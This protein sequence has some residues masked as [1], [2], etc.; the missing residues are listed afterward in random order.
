MAEKPKY[1][2]NVVKPTLSILHKEVEHRMIKVEDEV[3]MD[4]LVSELNS[5]M[6]NNTGRGKSDDVKDKLY[7][8]AIEKWKQLKDHLIGVH[9]NF[10][11]NRRQY[12][13]LTDLLLTKL[14]YDANTIFLAIELTDMLGEWKEAGTNKDDDSIKGYIADATEINY[15]YHLI[16]KHKMNGLTVQAYRFA[17]VIKSMLKVLQIVSYYDNHVKSLQSDI[18]KWVAFFEENMEGVGLE[19]KEELTGKKN[20]NKKVEA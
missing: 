6:A 7:S 15:I 16:T 2:T 12:Q 18:Q 11:L 8:E 1:E 9:Y 14:E 4:N 19:G 17:E 5:F 13:F 10:Y 3:V 20:K